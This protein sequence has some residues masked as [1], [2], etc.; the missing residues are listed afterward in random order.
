MTN[1]HK[2]IVAF[3]SDD[4]YKLFHSLTTKV[5]VGRISWYAGKLIQLGMKAEMARV[6][7]GK[8]EDITP[9]MELE[10]M[11]AKARWQEEAQLTLNY[12]VSRELTEQELERIH[13]IADQLDLDEDEAAELAKSPAFSSVVRHELSGDN[14]LGRCMAWLSKLFRE[15]ETL[16]RNDVISQGV[17]LGFKEHMINK[18]RVKL[19]IGTEKGN[20]GAFYWIRYTMPGAEED[21]IDTDATTN[22]NNNKIVNKQPKQHRGAEKPPF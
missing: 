10:I 17:A 9:M 4:D 21:D 11:A 1:Q 3:I 12:L 5:G 15:N 8:P 18:A 16:A 19:G 2:Q 20:G 13:A 6:G 14:L 22:T 7:E